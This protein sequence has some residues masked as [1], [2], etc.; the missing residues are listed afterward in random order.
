MKK[1]LSLMICLA[2]AAW[3][4]FS[5]S[6]ADDTHIEYVSLT[7]SESAARALDEMGII[8]GVGSDPTGR[9]SYGHDQF[10]TREEALA[11]SIRLLGKEEEALKGDWSSPFSDYSAWAA[12]YVGY[13]YQHGLTEGTSPTT[14]AGQK[15][16]TAEQFLTF[17]LRCLGYTD[18]E[19]FVW[20]APSELCEG[21]GISVP[22]SCTGYSF[23][24]GDA[25]FLTW[26]AMAARLKDSDDTLAKNLGGFP[27]G[28][29][30]PDVAVY[31]GNPTLEWHGFSWV[32]AI[33]ILLVYDPSAPVYSQ[34]GSL[35]GDRIIAFSPDGA[36]QQLIGP[37]FGRPIYDLTGF[38]RTAFSF[39]TSEQGEGGWISY[40]YHVEFNRSKPS[41]VELW[42]ESAV[43]EDPDDNERVLFRAE[44][45]RIQTLGLG[46][47]GVDLNYEIEDE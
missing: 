35:C 19:D 2:M 39:I 23:R 38:S 7:K 10:L 33:D 47:E 25:F 37:D 42:V 18:P 16:V 44:Q 28:N 13:G 29:D 11:I 40:A 32:D 20:N 45:Q 22:E 3:P 43:S 1:I 15:A 21:L 12:P 17:L 4:L 6:A 41:G 24:R 30:D 5:V 14:F 8:E 27:E 31:Y 34:D 26:Q 46:Y 9:I 36:E